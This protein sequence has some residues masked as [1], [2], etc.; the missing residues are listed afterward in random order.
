MV[1]KAPQANAKGKR[2]QNQVRNCFP[3]HFHL[4]HC[5]ERNTKFIDGI[6]KTPIGHLF[7]NMLSPEDHEDIH[8]SPNRR[9]ME[10]A[11]FARV[12]ED[13]REVYGKGMAITEAEIKA[14]MEYR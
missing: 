6:Y 11:R 2:W 9:M 5:R 7:I 13:T 3:G 4:H 12:I 10:R 8:K 1:G 14:C